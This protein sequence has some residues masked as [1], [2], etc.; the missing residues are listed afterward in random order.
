MNWVRDA[1]NRAPSSS[2]FIA[3]NKARSPSAR[4]PGA[5]LGRDFLA[6]STAALS[7]RAAPSTGAAPISRDSKAMRL[8]ARPRLSNST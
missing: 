1:Q 7:S 8:A 4:A 6:S 3:P 2:S 5:C